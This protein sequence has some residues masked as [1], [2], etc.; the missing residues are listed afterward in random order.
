MN[1][2]DTAIREIFH[3]L[4]RYQGETFVFTTLDA[5]VVSSDDLRQVASDL[6]LMHAL[7]INVVVCGSVESDL[8]MELQHYCQHSVFESTPDVVTK[9][10]ELDAV[11]ICLLGGIDTLSSKREAI[12]DIA[13][14]EAE[15]LLKT[16]DITGASRAVLVFAVR[17]CRA[18]IPR[19]HVMNIHQHGAFLTEIFTGHG[20]GTMIYAGTH[21]EVRRT[22]TED[23]SIV[24]DML[25]VFHPD[26]H[27]N[28]YLRD[29]MEDSR[30]FVADGEVYGFGHV[31]RSDFDLEVRR[32]VHTNRL[33][34]PEV[35]T[36]LLKSFQN[37]AESAGLTVTISSDVATA[38]KG[39][40]KLFASLGFKKQKRD[41][42]TTY[43]WGNNAS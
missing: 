15:A 30:V 34:A 33:N 17:A 31:V 43:V 26:D 28:N 20:A 12:D 4:K 38:L 3:H 10:R 27:A 22:G 24:S 14:S 11:K 39:Q 35:L 29:H 1:T 7:G 42:N 37:E 9:A 32:L 36:R 5:G 6:G 8:L 19:V 41:E 18:G 25:Q 21:K 23:I 16:S 2:E 13:V 40:Q